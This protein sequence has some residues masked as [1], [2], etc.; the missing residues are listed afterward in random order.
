[1]EELK[2]RI[3]QDGLIIDNRILKVDNFLNQQID[4][5]LIINIGKEFARIFS[6][7]PI[8]RIVT[9]ESSGIAIGLVTAAAMGNIPVVFARKKRSILM[10]DAVYASEVYSYTKEETY[11]ASISKTYLHE[12][13]NVLIVDDFLASGAAAL[14]LA[15]IVKQAGCHIAGIGIVIEKSFQPGRSRLEAAGYRVESLAR[16][17]EF[18]DNKPIFK[19]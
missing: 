19:D 16:I 2:R 5:N 7:C 8:D 10:R 15:D 11:T 14:G 1:M 18:R 12:G 3:L 4:A 6:D 13:E 9:I 17:A